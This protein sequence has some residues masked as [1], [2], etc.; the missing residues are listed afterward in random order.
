MGLCHKACDPFEYYNVKEFANFFVASTA[1]KFRNQGIASELY[2][3]SF[4]F[5][6]AEGFVMVKSVFTSPFS[7]SAAL[8]LGFEELYRLD[9]KDA[10]DTN[11]T[12]VFAQCKLTEEHYGALMCKKL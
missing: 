3:R 11:G 9:Y 10:I 2:K 12:P 8:K 7:R 5:L 1:T 6:A 4:A